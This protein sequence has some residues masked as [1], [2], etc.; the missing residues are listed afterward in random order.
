[1]AWAHLEIFKICS[2]S[3]ACERT[4]LQKKTDKRGNSIW[5]QTEGETKKFSKSD[6]IVRFFYDQSWLREMTMM[7]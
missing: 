6:S 1:M 5:Y 3:P 2:D 7:S 4:E